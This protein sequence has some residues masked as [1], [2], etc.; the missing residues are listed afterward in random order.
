MTVLDDRPHAH[1][2]L[3]HERR[4]IP[5]LRFRVTHWPKARKPVTLQYTKD[6]HGELDAWCTD[7]HGQSVVVKATSLV[8]FIEA[9]GS[10]SP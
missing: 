1:A 8:T 2:Q 9:E 10:V 5:G 4:L 6:N 3:I 7:G